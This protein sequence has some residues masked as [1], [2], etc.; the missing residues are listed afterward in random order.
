MAETAAADN[1]NRGRPRFAIHLEK[2]FELIYCHA[3]LA[4]DGAQGSTVQFGMIGDNDL[5][6]GILAAKYHMASMLPQ[7]LEA[8]CGQGLHAGMSGNAMYTDDTPLPTPN[9]NRERSR[10]TSPR[11]REAQPLPITLTERR[12]T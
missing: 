9:G 8:G 2:I 3:R 1:A 6:E 10:F 7:R 5:S 11:Y 12:S 4:D